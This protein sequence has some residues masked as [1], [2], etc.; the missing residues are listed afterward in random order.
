MILRP[1]INIMKSWKSLS[2]L[3]PQPIAKQ[4]TL[5]YPEHYNYV[6]YENTVEPDALFTD[7]FPLITDE[8]ILTTYLNDLAHGE[9]TYSYILSRYIPFCIN[10]KG[11]FKRNCLNQVCSIISTLFSVPSRDAYGIILAALDEHP[12]KYLPIES[13]SPNSYTNHFDL[14]ED[15]NFVE[16]ESIESALFIYLFIFS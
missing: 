6:R 9:I 12:T 15:D 11:E 16:I 2:K 4:I 14:E 13:F 5:P 3:V 1:K 10:T 8:T 7:I